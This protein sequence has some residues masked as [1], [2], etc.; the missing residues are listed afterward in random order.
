MNVEQFSPKQEKPTL[1]EFTEAELQQIHDGVNLAA[2]AAGLPE[3]DGKKL[4]NSIMR[5]VEE[6]QNEE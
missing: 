3:E 4:F 5:R 2:E 6:L 1:P